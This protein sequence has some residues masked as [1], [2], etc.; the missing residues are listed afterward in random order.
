MTMPHS[1][2]NDSQR[3]PGGI[4]VTPKALEQIHA[5]MARDGV[6]ADQG[7]MR[8]SVQ[9]GGCAGL[10]CSANVERQGGE[11]DRILQVDGARLFLDPKSFIFLFDSTLDYQDVPP[12]GFIVKSKHGT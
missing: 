12:A 4:A 9:G 8:L 10:S 2:S 3:D 7:G 6:S 11:R 1:N 5:A